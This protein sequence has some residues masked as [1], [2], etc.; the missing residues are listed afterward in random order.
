MLVYKDG[1]PWD[2]YIDQLG[3]NFRLKQDVVFELSEEYSGYQNLDDKW[4][5]M[6]PKY[7]GA[8]IEYT[9]I[10]E[11]GRG[12]V[13]RYVEGRG[14]NF[15]KIG[16]KITVFTPSVIEFI[17]G[18]ITCRA[19]NLALYFFL[20]NHPDCS[21]NKIYEGEAGKRRKLARTR[22]FVF[23]E[24]N[25]EKELESKIS[26]KDTVIELQHDISKT[27]LEKDLREMYAFYEQPNSQE[28]DIRTVK[29]FLLAEAERDPEK[30][31]G[32][33]KNASRSDY[34]LVND[35]QAAK[36]LDY[37]KNERLWKFAGQTESICSV[38]TGINAKDY[39]VKWLKENDV[40]NEVRNI[41]KQMMNKGADAVSAAV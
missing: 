9:F 13:L 5:R 22:P 16:N 38:P 20:I 12:S 6:F 18:R 17:Q 23:K 25:R 34:A 35:A 11:Q 31:K 7:L 3:K 37:Y 39:L 28:V 36:V 33:M 21:T 14:D 2:G 1:I 26:I 27:I 40:K 15:N 29:L 4:V 24:I 32:V 30:M 19:N 8:L 41:I 10:D